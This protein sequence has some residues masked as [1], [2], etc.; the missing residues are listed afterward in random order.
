MLVFGVPE[1]LLVLSLLLLVF[2]ARK[3]PRL[4]KSIAQSIREPRSSASQSLA[5]Q[6]PGSV[7][8]DGR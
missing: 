6:R 2:S 4:G 8:H 3:L 5:I 7:A 1:L